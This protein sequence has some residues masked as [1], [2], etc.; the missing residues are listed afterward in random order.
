LGKLI[1][2]TAE[3]LLAKFIPDGVLN[4]GLFRSTV[5]GS[6]IKVWLLGVARMACAVLHSF[7]RG[8]QRMASDL[9]PKESGPLGRLKPKSKHLQVLG[10]V[11]VVIVFVALILRLLG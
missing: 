10:V 5:G 1:C 4:D 3:E 9:T 6:S 2:A 7:H 8:Q 11:M